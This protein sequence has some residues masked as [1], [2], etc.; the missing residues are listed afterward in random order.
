[1]CL[2]N[3]DA[4]APRAIGSVASPA[5]CVSIGHWG[6]SS[7]LP[8]YQGR[9]FIWR[10][11]VGELYNLARG[12]MSICFDTI[13]EIRGVNPF[14]GVSSSQAHAFRPGWRKPLPVLVRTN[15]RPATP[16]RTNM[17]PDGNG[18]FYLYLHGSMRKASGTEVGDRVRVEIEFDASYRNGP[19]HPMP[20]RFKQ[21]LDGNP[22]AKKNWTA[23]IP[24][25]K[26]EILRYFSRLVAVDARARNL[27][28]ALHVLSGQAGRFMGRDWKDGS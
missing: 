9:S 14:V 18:N 27:A 16:W 11:T 24:S 8:T 5:V 6:I 25:R 10:S 1:V 19:Q 26:K 13:I 7:A 12:S 15:G 21:A 22:Q 4:A 2:V 20:K 28:R 23:L 17:M 3:R